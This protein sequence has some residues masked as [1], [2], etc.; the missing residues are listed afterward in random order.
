VLEERHEAL[1]D[2]LKAADMALLAPQP[3]VLRGKCEEVERP[4]PQVRAVRRFRLQ[5]PPPRLRDPIVDPLE[6]P[7]DVRRK[8][9][10]LRKGNFRRVP[11]QRN[12]FSGGADGV[13]STA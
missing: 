6:R 13:S 3:L 11:R 5:L 1:L 9:R 2:R 7:D 4:Q 8:C 12:R 10:E